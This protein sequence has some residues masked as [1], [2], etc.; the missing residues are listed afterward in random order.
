MQQSAGTAE[1]GQP[2]R[3]VFN[4]KGTKMAA[5]RH[6]AGALRPWPRGGCLLQG[7][8]QLLSYVV[9]PARGG[10]GRAGNEI[11][12]L[13]PRVLTKGMHFLHLQ[14]QKLELCRKLKKFMRY[15]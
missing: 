1:V 6:G 5:Y 11:V 14:L 7:G 3:G 4:Q 15:L 12:F 13:K 2:V 10:D 9:F 8:L